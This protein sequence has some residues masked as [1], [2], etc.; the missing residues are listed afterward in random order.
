MSGKGSR[1]R[2]FSVTQKEFDNSFDTIFGQKPK[3]EPYVPPPT[4][5]EVDSA[6]KESSEEKLKRMFGD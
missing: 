4:N 3:K 2:P 5:I 6:P 1:P